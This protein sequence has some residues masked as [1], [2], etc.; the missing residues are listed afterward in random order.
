M[1]NAADEPCPLYDS[2]VGYTNGTL[3]YVRT[4]V[5]AGR[6][7]GRQ[8][9]IILSMHLSV[10]VC[11]VCLSQSPPPSPPPHSPTHLYTPHT[12]TQSPVGRPL[13]SPHTEDTSTI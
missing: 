11:V 7:A 3:Q 1:C 2:R 6:Q 4:Y 12:H 13:V 10:G 5:R 8:A 9:G